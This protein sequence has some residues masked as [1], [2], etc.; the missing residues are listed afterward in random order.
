MRSDLPISA[1]YIL[2][3]SAR[4]SLFHEHIIS[5][6]T[7]LVPFFFCVHACECTDACGSLP[8]QAISHA[9]CLQLPSICPGDCPVSAHRELP[10]SSPRLLHSHPLYEQTITYFPDPGYLHGFQFFYSKKQC[11][12]D[13][14]V[15]I[16]RVH[17]LGSQKPKG[18]VKKNPLH[19]YCWKVFLNIECPGPPFLPL[20]ATEGVTGLPSLSDRRPS[21][22]HIRLG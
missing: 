21:E 4:I 7:F 13:G 9:A 11:C 6:I 19:L 8:H 16:L 12:S 22:F 20:V 18:R 2:E 10:H 5:F 17:R 1:S 3:W 15:R 14:L